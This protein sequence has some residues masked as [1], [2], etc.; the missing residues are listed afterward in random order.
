M[1]TEGLRP[2]ARSAHSMDTLGVPA[3]V[4]GDFGPLRNR[5]SSEQ[6]TA[7][8]AEII[9]GSDARQPATILCRPADVDIVSS[10]RHTPALE[11]RGR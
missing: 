5:L 9:L 3:G 10:R 11:A 1:D 2:P 8:A 6:F 4:R 7:G